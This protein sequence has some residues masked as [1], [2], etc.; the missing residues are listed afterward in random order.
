MG[1]EPTQPDGPSSRAEW[2]RLITESV[3]RRLRF[4]GGPGV[5]IDTT[6]NAVVIQIEPQ[7][8]KNAAQDTSGAR[9]S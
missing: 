9:W 5:K 8:I 3:L 7:A 4:V 6:T 2:T 1:Y